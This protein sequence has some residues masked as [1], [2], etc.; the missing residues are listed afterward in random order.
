MQVLVGTREVLLVRAHH[1]AEYQW[2]TLFKEGWNGHA[3][4]HNGR[5]GV[6][7]EREV[8]PRQLAGIFNDFKGRL[9]LLNPCGYFGMVGGIPGMITQPFDGF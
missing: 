4:Q 7:D 3:F 2:V 1:G 8:E 6:R 5:V 9:A